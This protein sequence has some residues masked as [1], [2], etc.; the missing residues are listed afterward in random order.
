MYE[1]GLEVFECGDAFGGIDMPTYVVLLNWSQQGI[2]NVKES[3]TRL[4]A[5]KQAFEQAGGQLKGFYMVMG[6]YDMVCIVEAPNDEALAKVVLANAAKGSVRTQ[7][8]RAFTED[9][10]RKIIAALP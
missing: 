10:Y 7:T 3:A 1:S 4:D 2:T 6:Q 5:V 9:E 8:L